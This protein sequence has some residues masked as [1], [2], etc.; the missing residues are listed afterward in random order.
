MTAT[1]DVRVQSL[2][3]RHRDQYSMLH[4]PQTS[5]ILGYIRVEIL[6]GC[7]PALLNHSQTSANA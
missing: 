3:L 5:K 7:D 1:S 2:G 6:V 4:S